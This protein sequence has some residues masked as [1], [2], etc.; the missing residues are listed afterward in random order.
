MAPRVWGDSLDAPPPKTRGTPSG[1]TSSVVRR[2]MFLTTMS[3]GTA[4]SLL[5]WASM[6]D[7]G[8]RATTGC[9]CGAPSD[10]S[11]RRAAA[12]TG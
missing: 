2:T 5:F 12:W 8:G 6:A 10:S 9:P 11:A 1:A 4:S 7:E 3:G